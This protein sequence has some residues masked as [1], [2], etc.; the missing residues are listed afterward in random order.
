[1]NKNLGTGDKVRLCPS[2]KFNNGREDN[3]IGIVGKVTDCH[4]TYDVWVGVEW[5]NDTFNQYD[6]EASDLIKIN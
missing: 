3:P 1:M 6:P 2:S 5:E 4:T